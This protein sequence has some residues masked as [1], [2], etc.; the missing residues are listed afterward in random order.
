MQK[1]SVHLTRDCIRFGA[2]E[3]QTLSKL[4][5]NLPGL[6]FYCSQTKTQMLEN[7]PLL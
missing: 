6:C 1:G 4:K 2:G 7:D 3:V 5:K